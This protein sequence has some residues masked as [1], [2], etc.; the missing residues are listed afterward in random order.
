MRVLLDTTRKMARYCCLY[1]MH[2]SIASYESAG[3]LTGSLGQIPCYQVTQR[4]ETFDPEIPKMDVQ[5]ASE[6]AR[7]IC[8]VDHSCQGRMFSMVSAKRCNDLQHTLA[9]MSP[10]VPSQVKIAMGYRLLCL[11]PEYVRQKNTTCRTRRNTTY[12]NANTSPIWKRPMCLVLPC[13][14]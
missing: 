1:T 2:L 13:R 8:R 14:L 3:L 11:N 6:H 5:M 10:S 12:Q 4:I 7:P 9:S